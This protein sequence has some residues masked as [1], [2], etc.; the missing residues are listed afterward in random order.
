LHKLCRLPLLCCFFPVAL[1]A[2]RQYYVGAV[3]GIATLSSAGQE[4]VTPSSAAVSLYSTRNEPAVNLF[5]GLH[6]SNYVSLQGNYIWNRND[7]TL[8]STAPGGILQNFY[9]QPRSGSQ[10]SVMAD[11]LVYMRDRRS[12]VRPYLSG[13]L[14]P[15]HLSSSIHGQT[16]SEGAAEGA[17]PGVHFN[18]SRTSSSGGNGRPAKVRLV[19]PIQLQRNHQQQP[20]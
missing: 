20:H 12:R 2:Q 1:C 16:T 10:H 18:D 9:Q 19:L 8:T 3:G 13:G 7:L 15:V 5:V 11:L 4:V 6:L 17:S 14:G